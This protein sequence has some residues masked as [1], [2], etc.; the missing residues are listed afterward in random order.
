M[1]RYATAR[2]M[3][4][5]ASGT[6]G[7]LLQGICSDSGPRRPQGSAVPRGPGE[8]NEKAPGHGLGGASDVP[9][10]FSERV[11]PPATSYANA[12]VQFAVSPTPNYD[13]PCVS[14]REPDAWN[15][16]GPRSTSRVGVSP[17]RTVMECRHLSGGP[18]PGINRPSAFGRPY[19]VSPSSSG[20]PPPTPVVVDVVVG[21]VVGGDDD[22][23]GSDAPAGGAG[24]GAA[25]GDGTGSGSGGVGSL[26]ALAA[27]VGGVVTAGREGGAVVGTA[28]VS[29]CAGP[30][31][32]LSTAIT[33]PKPTRNAATHASG[34][35]TRPPTLAK[36][37]RR[38][39][40]SSAASIVS[41][42]ASSCGRAAPPVSGSAAGSVR[43]PSAS[44]CAAGSVASSTRTSLAPTS[45][46]AT[47]GGFRNSFV[48]QTRVNSDS[49]GCF[50][51]MRD[52][53]TVVPSRS[54]LVRKFRSMSSM[55]GFIPWEVF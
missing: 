17:G 22:G 28:F 23:G 37:E 26:A 52:L 2:K 50:F 49:R 38:A 47:T 7:C 13:H 18:R 15:E 41:Q 10:G 6:G 3:Q 8:S 25:S 39:S 24:A 20:A 21:A 55:V 40:C 48:R 53:S 43:A 46:I 29:G 54:P 9:W 44:R 27:L 4:S 30:S 34:S 5:P 36:K 19:S 42:S 11:L 51:Q 45:A 14:R 35:T 31:S 16:R 32:R 33:D 12:P 1:S